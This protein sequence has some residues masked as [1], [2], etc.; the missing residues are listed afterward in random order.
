MNITD[1]L[2]TY[3]ISGKQ[4]IRECLPLAESL[5]GKDNK[6]A[7]DFIKKN[8]DIKLG[9]ILIKDIMDASKI[10]PVIS[11]VSPVSPVSTTNISDTN[12]YLTKDVN[13][14]YHDNK[15]EIEKWPITFNI[16]VIKDKTML[17]ITS[18]KD[19][20]KWPKS[21][22]T[23]DKPSYASIWAL[24][25][26]NGKKYAGCCDGI[27]QNIL[28]KAVRDISGRKIEREPVKGWMP[29]K[30]ERV[31]IFLTGL[32]RGGKTNVK[33]RSNCVWITW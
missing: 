12:E 20:K 21:N 27:K 17:N 10:I 13:I 18:D 30:G 28:S 6:P 3:N 32:A 9:D 24:F 31:G 33:E 25:D 29:Q 8:L 4:T 2:V 7:F 11:S 22:S 23:S 16:K 26:Y 15:V 5:Y 19:L 1:L 14:I